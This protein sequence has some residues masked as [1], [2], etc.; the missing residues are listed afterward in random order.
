MAR[1]SRYCGA[2][3]VVLVWRPRYGS[4]EVNPP[5][6]PG[7][8]RDGGDAHSSLAPEGTPRVDSTGGFGASEGTAPRVLQLKGHRGRVYGLTV[9]AGGDIVCT[10]DETGDVFVWSGADHSVKHTL[11][12]HTAV[13][14]AIAVSPDGTD[15]YSASGDRTVRVWSLNHGGVLLRELVGHT[16]TVTAVVVRQSHHLLFVEQRKSSAKIDVCMDS[17]PACALCR[18]TLLRMNCCSPQLKRG[19]LVCCALFALLPSHLCT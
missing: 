4:G 19:E 5:A 6:T 14:N 18:R 10:G 11:R 12:G 17:L 13:I 2:T 9:G 3:E 15:V 1:V 8:T 7:R 16:A